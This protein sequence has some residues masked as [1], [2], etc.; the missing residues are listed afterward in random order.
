MNAARAYAKTQ[1]ETA[2]KERLMALLFERALLL[3]RTGAAELEAGRVHEG[4]V[5]MT[6]A[7]DIVAELSATLDV[8]KAPELGQ[9]LKDVYLFVCGRLVKAATT[10]QAEAAR[11][12]ER[13]FA[14]VAEAFTSAVAQL[15]SPQQVTP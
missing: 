8:T 12:A 15:G 6:K 1:T 9:V 5:A 4:K 3:M 10:G 2:S 11:E 7:G 13:V 14:P